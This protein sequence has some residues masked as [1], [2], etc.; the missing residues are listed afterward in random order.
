MWCAS[1]YHVI[2]LKQTRSIRN[3]TSKAPKKLW[4]LRFTGK[5]NNYLMELFITITQYCI[6]FYEQSENVQIPD[7]SYWIALENKYDSRQSLVLLP[8]TATANRNA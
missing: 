7:F 4:V 8:F 1:I 5:S 3:V 2:G 6:L